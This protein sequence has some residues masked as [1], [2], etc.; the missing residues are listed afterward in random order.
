MWLPSVIFGIF[1]VVAA[2]LL[3]FMP[4][5]MGRPLQESI[6]GSE[7]AWAKKS[8]IKTVSEEV[9]KN[10]LTNEAFELEETK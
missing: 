8:D 5:T 10:E 1:S 9:T 7:A 4:E 6:V 2:L 3:I